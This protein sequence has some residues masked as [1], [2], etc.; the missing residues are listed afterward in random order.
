MQALHSLFA[1][2]GVT[3]QRLLGLFTVSE[4]TMQALHSL[5]TVCD[6]NYTPGRSVWQAFLSGFAGR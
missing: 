5:F 3:M 4:M 6:W 2:F 1:V